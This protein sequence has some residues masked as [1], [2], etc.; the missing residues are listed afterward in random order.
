MSELW[1][2]LASELAALIVRKEASSREVLEAHLAR[3]EAVNPKVNAIVKVLA[4]EA[5]NG[6]DEADRKLAAKEALGPLH[7]VPLRSRKTSIWRARRPHGDCQRSRGRRFP[8]RANRGEDAQGRGGADRSDQSSRHGAARSH[9]QFAA[10]RHAQSLASRTDR[11]RFKRG[12]SCGSSHGY[13]APRPWQRH[14]RLAAQSCQRLRHR[15]DQAFPGPRAR[16][17][18]HSGSRSPVSRADHAGERADGEDRRRRA[19]CAAGDLGRHHAIPGRSILP[20]NGRATRRRAA[21]P[22]SPSLRAAPRTR[23]WRRPPDMLS[24]RSRRLATKTP[25]RPGP[26]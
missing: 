23:L 26:R 17:R 11:R 3:I 5:R 1:R 15:I 4:K 20:R 25:S 9:P 10:R 13:V 19:A 14:R 6:A 24:K 16:R 8:R 2:R 21:S 18:R 12:R 7:G 22:W